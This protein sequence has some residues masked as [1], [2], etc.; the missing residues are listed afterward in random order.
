MATLAAITLDR[1]IAPTTPK[2]VQPAPNKKQFSIDQLLGKTRAN[3]KVVNAIAEEIAREEVQFALGIAPVIVDWNETYDNHGA[4]TAL[5][6]LCQLVIDHELEFAFRH[7]IPDGFQQALADAQDTKARPWEQAIMAH[8]VAQA[9]RAEQVSIAATEKFCNEFNQIA[10]QFLSFPTQYNSLTMPVI[11]Q[12]S[13]IWRVSEGGNLLG[14]AQAMLSSSAFKQKYQE[15]AA[16]T[17]L[18]KTPKSCL[19]YLFQDILFWS[20][21]LG[22]LARAMYDSSDLRK[23][24]NKH[25]GDRI[26]YAKGARRAQGPRAKVNRG[27]GAERKSADRAFFTDYLEQEEA[28]HADIVDYPEEPSDYKPED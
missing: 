27:R 5:I 2:A 25:S 1:P 28:I 8:K 16:K 10:R 15:L 18:P 21:H 3:W 4:K 24:E 7:R 20:D 12:L 22:E 23:G 17:Y 14:K 19:R 11:K 9:V 26:A 13:Y 6:Q